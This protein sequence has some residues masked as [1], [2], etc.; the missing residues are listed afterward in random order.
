MAPVDN[1]PRE[2]MGAFDFIYS[3]KANDTIPVHIYKSRDT[4]ITVC[5]ADVEGPV[6]NGYFCLGN[7][8]CFYISYYFNIVFILYYYFIF[9]N[10]C[11]YLYYIYNIFI[12][13][14][15]IYIHIIYLYIYI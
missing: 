5:I 3:I 14:Y 9:I 13:M 8:F 12:Y 7:F 6:V 11:I 15:I 4:G 10:I 1:S 2:N